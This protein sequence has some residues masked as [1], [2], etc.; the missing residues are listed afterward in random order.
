MMIKVSIIFLGYMATGTGL[1]QIKSKKV[2]KTV[3]I[4]PDSEVH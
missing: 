1:K 4:G 3:V 2:F